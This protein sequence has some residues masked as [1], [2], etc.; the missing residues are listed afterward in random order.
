MSLRPILLAIVG[1]SAAGKSTLGAGIAAL[2]GEAR[3]TVVTTDDYH[4]HNRK[5][6]LQ[7]SRSAP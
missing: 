5:T 2:L 3:V 6:R 1:D 7:R 4:K